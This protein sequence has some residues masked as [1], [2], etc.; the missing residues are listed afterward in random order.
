M[1][2]RG[3]EMRPF[4]MHARPEI[5][6]SQ[7]SCRRF[8]GVGRAP[9]E[10]PGASIGFSVALG[11]SWSARLTANGKSGIDIAAVR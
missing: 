10:K 8:R 4:L 6:N 5:R 11:F 2:E 7:S 1:T 3:A 9:S